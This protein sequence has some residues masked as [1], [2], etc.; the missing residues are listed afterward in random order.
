[1]NPKPTLCVLAALG[2]LPTLAFAITPTITSVSGTVQS[3]LTL[4]ITGSSMIQEDRTNWDPLFIINPNASGFEGLSPIADGYQTNGCPAYTT[5]VKLMG[6][7][8]IN[9]HNQGQHIRLPDGSGLASCNWQ[10][11]IQASLPLTTWQD[12]YLRSYSRW[13]N[14]SWA[15][16]DVKYWW[17]QGGPFGYFWSFRTNAD[18]SPPTRFGITDPAHFANWYEGA[19]PGGAMQNNKWYLFEGHFRTQG[20]GNY[21]IELWVDN[22]LIISQAVAS[23]VS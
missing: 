9:M 12:V 8:S 18:G 13:N 17:T 20:S 19:I 4:T 22:Q 10:W 7:R 15:T 5:A 6:S 14:T 21:V 2:C 1:M 23:G 16:H 3:G 11:V